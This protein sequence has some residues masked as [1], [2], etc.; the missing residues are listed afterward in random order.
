MIDHINIPVS[1]LT[2]ARAFYDAVLT[3]LGYACIAEDG[4]AVGYGHD[5]W[6]FG[7][8]QADAPVTP[9]H[10]AFTAPSREAVTAFHTAALKAGGTCNGVPG[11]RPQ[12]GTSYFAAFIT[13]PD[14][15]NIEAVARGAA[16]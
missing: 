3:P 2:A 5:N 1:D 10:I 6:S 15:H 4:D 16:C 14:G 12:Y 7:I 8:V 11:A 9:L 13:D